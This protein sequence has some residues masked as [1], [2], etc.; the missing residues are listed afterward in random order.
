MIADPL[1]MLIGGGVGVVA[2][3][4]F[5]RYYKRGER[6]ERKA[7]ERTVDDY[8]LN[9]SKRELV[10]KYR[11]LMRE[12]PRE[13]LEQ[14]SKTLEELEWRIQTEP[15][16]REREKELVSK[17]MEIE[18][19]LNRQRKALALRSKINELDAEM[20]E[21][22]REL[23]E[24]NMKIGQNSRLLDDEEFRRMFEERERLRG[25]LDE[26]KG[27]IR[28]KLGELEELSKR[29]EEE[30]KKRASSDSVDMN[31]LLIESRKKIIEKLERGEK[32]NFDELRI[33]YGIDLNR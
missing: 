24:C 30:R 17:A 14:L 31:A 7:V 22:E 12:L 2:G 15:L 28:E 11:R 4:L 6:T 32:L 10:S 3:F 27:K 33:L 20:E 16:S 13:S 8:E 25:E 1:S 9:R 19:K 5:S 29:L 21:V 18:L 26:I 23:D